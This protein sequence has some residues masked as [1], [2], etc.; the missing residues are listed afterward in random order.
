MP[1][2]SPTSFVNDFQNHKQND[3]LDLI[4]M[5]K[6]TKRFFIKAYECLI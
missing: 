1:Y 6:S 5:P 2:E 3:E 4:L